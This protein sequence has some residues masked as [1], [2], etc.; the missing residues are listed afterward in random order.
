[1]KFKTA[2]IG[3]KFTVV[4]ASLEAHVLRVPKSNRYNKKKLVSYIH[5]PTF[6]HF[7]RLLQ[8]KFQELL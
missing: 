4:D 3:T 5:T 7:N 8:I 2:D 6:E 1:M